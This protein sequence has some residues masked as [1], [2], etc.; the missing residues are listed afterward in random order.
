MNS[1]ST[2]EPTPAS[3]SRL[4]QALV[5]LQACTLF[6]VFAFNSGPSAA[7]AAPAVTSSEP[8]RSTL[9]NAAAQRAEQIDLLRQVRD[10]VAR[11]ADSMEKQQ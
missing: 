10:Q 6:A 1:P 9:P 7:E 3:Q 2:A 4:L 8:L 11:V 5:A